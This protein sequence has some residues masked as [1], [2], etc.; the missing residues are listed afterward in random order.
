MEARKLLLKGGARRRLGL[1]LG[2]Q[3]AAVNS[4]FFIVGGRLRLEER[5]VEERWLVQRRELEVLVLQRE[6]VNL[7]LATR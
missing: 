6:R 2:E 1:E 7:S 5:V 3:R 4:S